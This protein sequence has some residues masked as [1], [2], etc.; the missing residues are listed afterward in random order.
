MNSCGPGCIMCRIVSRDKDTPYQHLMKSNDTPSDILFENNNW[1][2]IL[3]V[4][5]IVEGW[6]LIVHRSHITSLSEANHEVLEALIPI[7]NRLSNTIYNAYGVRPFFL[8]HGG[9]GEHRGGACIAHAHLHVIPF[10]GE[11]KKN[12]L[13]ECEFD[14]IDGIWDLKQKAHHDGYLYFELPN[15]ESFLANKPNVKHQLIRRIVA[16]ALPGSP[17]WEWREYL[18]RADDLGTRKK[19]LNAY[20]MLSLEQNNL[21]TGIN[22]FKLVRDRIPSL[23]GPIA[24]N[25][26]ISLEAEET[27][28]KLLAEKLLEESLEYQETNSIEELGDIQEVILTLLRHHKIGFDEFMKLVENKRMAK[29]GFH[30]GW[31]M[32]LSNNIQSNSIN[33]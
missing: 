30:A 22:R 23:A 2:G 12:L 32:S 27:V 17:P 6:S 18:L 8:E 24:F 13:R 15:G 21:G 10:D 29:G 19:L 16:A 33:E 9:V 4:A 20:T 3:D 14:K 28:S 7:K 31:A 25:R 5:P 26:F 11:I 1:V